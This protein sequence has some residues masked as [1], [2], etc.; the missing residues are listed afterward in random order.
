[1]YVDLL[2]SLFA[3]G[4]LTDAC[5]R[6]RV[7]DRVDLVVAARQET[8]LNRVNRMISSRGEDVGLLERLERLAASST[9][10]KQ[11][12]AAAA[13]AQTKK[14]QRTKRNTKGRKK[15]KKE[16]RKEEAPNANGGEKRGKGK[17]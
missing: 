8:I 2:D 7:P 10:L 1:M 17:E 16:K 5:S 12:A 4:H 6:C 9:D 3:S 15:A 13:E 14:R 11:G